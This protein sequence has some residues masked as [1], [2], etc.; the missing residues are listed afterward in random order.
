MSTAAQILGKFASELKLEDIPAEVLERAKICIIDTV[1]AATF[2][3]RFAWSK[4]AVEYAIRYGK[5][6]P[7]SIIGYPAVRVQAPYAALSN[8]VLSQ[9]Y[10]QDSVSDPSHGVHPGATLLP[11]LLAASEETGGDGKTALAAFVA[12]CEIM[13]RIGA[14]SHHSPE[15]IGFHSPAIAGTYGAA[16]AAGRVYGLN[17]EQMTHAL[18][19]AGSLS[20]GIL[21]FGKS[22]QGAMVKRLHVGRAAESGILAARLASSGYTGPET[23]LDGKFGFLDTYC[24]GQVSDAKLLTAE[25]HEY[26]KTL[27]ICFKRYSCEKYSHPPVQATR[28][29]MAEHNFV[30]HDVDTVRVEGNE[31]LTTH[32]N[33]TEPADIMKAQYS[34]PFCVALALF[35]NPEDPQSFDEQAVADPAIRA[36]CRKIKL[37]TLPQAGAGM[38]ARVTVDL[39]DGRRVTADCSLYRGMPD[40]TF[41]RD[42]VRR[43]FMLFTSGMGTEAAARL[44]ARLENIEQEPIFSL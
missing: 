27:R 16:A 3:G 12:G 2:G 18:G 6:G 23:V 19:I 15:K 9:A 26:W 34:V 40:N 42:D 20:S 28:T 33:I 41:S 22:Q 1:A 21:A 11:A 13:F 5:G 44:C 4:M 8:G 30:G 37:G 24:N 7:C 39:K 35:R 36:M 25:L 17:A 29:L 10:E 31:R 43:K 14:A 38:S 32:H